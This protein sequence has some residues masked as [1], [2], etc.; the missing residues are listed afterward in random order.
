MRACAPGCHLDYAVSVFRARKTLLRTRRSI[1]ASPGG[2]VKTPGSERRSA[3]PPVWA[4]TRG[5]PKARASRATSGMP[6]VREA[7]P[8]RGLGSARLGTTHTAASRSAVAT[9]VGE[10]APG[11]DSSTPS[12]AASV[13]KRG[14]SGPSPRRRTGG[15]TGRGRPPTAR[16]RRS[17]PL[18]GTRRPTPSTWCVLGGGVAARAKS[19]A[20]TGM[21]ATS[22]GTP[23]GQVPKS[24]RSCRAK[25]AETHTTRWQR[26]TIH[27]ANAAPPGAARNHAR[28]P[29][30]TK[31]VCGKPGAARATARAE[32][33]IQ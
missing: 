13:C 15:R 20:S 19:A 11:M 1:R 28:S 3:R 5:V 4:T 22:S 10:T 26:G 25:G 27:R 7:E 32:G 24:S 8:A 33:T 14:A 23:A 12:R 21:G 29:E 18:M 31:L 17:N 9:V 2:N 30:C 16:N 6:S